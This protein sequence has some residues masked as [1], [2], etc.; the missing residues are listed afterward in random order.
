MYLTFYIKFYF[1]YF[2]KKVEQN[3]YLNANNLKY[4]NNIIKQMETENNIKNVGEPW[5]QEEDEQLNKLYNID[6]LDIIEISKIHN[7]APGE[8][9][10]RLCKHNYIPNR[11]S[12][13][14]YMIYKKSDLYK[15]IVFS[16][17]LKRRENKERR[18]TKEE[19]KKSKKNNNMIKINKIDYIELQNVVKDMKNEII[20]LKTTIKELVEM[21]KAVYEFEDV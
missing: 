6:M 20:E 9:I 5:L 8:I 4:K 19:I 21:M 18:E 12:A 3:I 10:S 1:L 11:T 2:F 13:R 17:E 16:S 15:Q 14:G 7:R